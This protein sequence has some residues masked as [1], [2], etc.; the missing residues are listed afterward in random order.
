MRI[1]SFL[2]WYIIQFFTLFFKG[3]STDLF[4]LN[5]QNDRLYNFLA[6]TLW[7]FFPIAL[8]FESFRA[9]PPHA[10]SKCYKNLFV[11]LGHYNS[12]LEINNIRIFPQ[13]NIVC[14]PVPIMH[15]HIVFL[16]YFEHSFAFS[17]KISY[18]SIRKQFLWGQPRLR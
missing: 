16:N 7:N 9:F 8:L 10:I 18:N 5:R 12:D 17:W 14:L 4:F 1:F 15:H 3:K 6:T 11:V 13:Q 2:L